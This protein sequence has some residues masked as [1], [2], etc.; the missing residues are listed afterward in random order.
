MLHS[1]A[2]LAVQAGGTV[3]ARSWQAWQFGEVREPDVRGIIA[4]ERWQELPRTWALHGRLPERST[5]R[6]GF[7]P[8]WRECED[9]RTTSGSPFWPLGLSGFS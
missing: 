5:Q 2:Q 8:G 1:Q 9:E 7:S 6:G 4:R 3:G